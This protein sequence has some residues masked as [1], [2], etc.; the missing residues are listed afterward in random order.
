PRESLER[1]AGRALQPREGR[2]EELGALD[3]L[4]PRTGQQDVAA[5]D[6]PAEPAPSA[7]SGADHEHA[8]VD[9]R[10]DNG[11]LAESEQAGMDA[12][13][14]D[15][16]RRPGDDP[17]DRPLPGDVA[18]V[19][20]VERRDHGHTALRQRDGARQAVVRVDEVD[21]LGA[22]QLPQPFGGAGVLERALAAVEC[23]HV[24]LD[25]ELTQ[26]LDLVVH[27]RARRRLAFGRPHVRQAQDPHQSSQVVPGVRAI[28]R[29]RPISTATATVG[30]ANAASLKRAIRTYAAQPRKASWPT[31]CARGDCRGSRRSESAERKS[32]STSRMYAV[33]STTP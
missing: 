11:R 29:A 19:A 28:P 33:R 32:Q 14:E 23:E 31:S 27:E 15:R 1:D 30:D 3:G 16:R 25:A 17:R 6:A 10:R 20:A 22:Q 4:R 12:G 2:V 21:L 24:D 26:I 8:G 9:P 13:D 18:D 5:V 7:V